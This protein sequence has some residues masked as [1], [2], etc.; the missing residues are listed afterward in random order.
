MDSIDTAN[1]E[2]QALMERGERI[3]ATMWDSHD[4]VVSALTTREIT[5][6]QSRQLAQ[7]RSILDNG[8]PALVHH[9]A[10]VLCDMFDD[11][12]FEYTADLQE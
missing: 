1:E 7:L 6:E 3:R 11:A 4:T 8:H 12:L 9:A 10:K 2:Y 5:H